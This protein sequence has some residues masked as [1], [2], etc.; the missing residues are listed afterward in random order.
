MTRTSIT[1]LLDWAP[2]RQHVYRR[3]WRFVDGEWR[4]VVD[5]VTP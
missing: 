1:L 2:K 4:L 3:A 5:L